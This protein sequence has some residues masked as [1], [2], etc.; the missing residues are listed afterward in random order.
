MFEVNEK[1]GTPTKKAV[2]KV[3]PNTITR[4]IKTKSV[5]QVMFCTVHFNVKTFEKL[6]FYF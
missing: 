6:F 1:E 5:K 4:N 2:E 3:T